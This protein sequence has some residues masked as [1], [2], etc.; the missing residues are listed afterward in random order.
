[1]SPIKVTFR[2]RIIVNSTDEV[3][4]KVTIDPGTLVARGIYGPPPSAG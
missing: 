4:L 1:V 2:F 3:D